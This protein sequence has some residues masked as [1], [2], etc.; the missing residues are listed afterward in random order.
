M[1][2]QPMYNAN[3]PPEMA[4]PMQPQYIPSQEEINQVKYGPTVSENTDILT[5]VINNVKGPLVVF[6]ILVLMLI[7]FIDKHLSKLIPKLYSGNNGLSYLGV[8][9]KSI[10]GSL[11]F[12]LSTLI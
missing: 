10:I 11:L 8:L 6:V 12:Y 2:S 9:V 1:P 3:I 5:M 7:P 4:V